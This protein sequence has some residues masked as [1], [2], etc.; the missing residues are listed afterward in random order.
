MT[1]LAITFIAIG[2]LCMAY[3]AFSYFRLAPPALAPRNPPPP[4]KAERVPDIG[5]GGGSFDFADPYAG[6]P[7][8]GSGAV[9]RRPGSRPART[10]TE[11]CRAEAEAATMME[12][13]LSHPREDDQPAEHETKRRRREKHADLEELRRR[14]TTFKRIDTESLNDRL[15][16]FEKTEHHEPEPEQLIVPGTL[17]LDHGRKIPDQLGRGGDL[18]A[19]LFSELRRIGKGTMILESGRFLIHSGNASYSYSA[20]D[21]DQIVFQPGGLALVPIPSDRAIPVFLTP[22]VDEIKAHIKKNARIRAV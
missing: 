18:P 8:A 12:D 6:D 7:Y 20:G 2:L 11:P 22:R 4:G 9:Y 17:Y 13:D 14:L 19:R 16:I 5:P 10:A 15:R 3:V 21:L 1:Y